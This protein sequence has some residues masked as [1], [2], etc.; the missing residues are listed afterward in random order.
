MRKT[1]IAILLLTIGLLSC[2]DNSVQEAHYD[3]METHDEIM[4]KMEMMLDLKSDLMDRLEE[5]DSNIRLNRVEFDNAILKLEDGMDRMKDWM[6]NYKIPKKDEVPEAALKY[7][8]DQKKEIIAVGLK[9]D[10]SIES[11]QKLL[12]NDEE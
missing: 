1:Q 4:F 2:S 11:A 12:P 7:L 6:K 8:A 5:P 10:K 9:M 3:V